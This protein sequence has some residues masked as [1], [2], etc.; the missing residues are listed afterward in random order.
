MIQK[1]ISAY[2]EN[3]PGQL[4]DYIQVLGENNIDR[5]PRTTGS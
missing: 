1:Q 4:L 5:T 2:L 3:K